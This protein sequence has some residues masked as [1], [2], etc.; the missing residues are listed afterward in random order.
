MNVC[1]SHGSIMLLN[2]GQDYLVD[3]EEWRHNVP[4]QRPGAKE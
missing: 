1:R 4:A 2:H 3:L